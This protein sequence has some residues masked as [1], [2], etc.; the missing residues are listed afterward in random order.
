V[1]IDFYPLIYASPA[2]G[3]RKKKTT[4]SISPNV[5]APGSSSFALSFGKLRTGRREGREGDKI[6]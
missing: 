3:E 4:L 5:S 2:R 6:R 1:I